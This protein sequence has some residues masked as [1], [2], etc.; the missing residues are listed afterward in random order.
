MKFMIPVKTSNI[1]IVY[2]F[3]FLICSV[4][5]INC[6]VEQ[7]SEDKTSSYIE[8]NVVDTAASIRDS[9]ANTFCKEF[10]PIKTVDP[11]KLK[12]KFFKVG[13]FPFINFIAFDTCHL[14]PVPRNPL[15]ELLVAAF[16]NQGW[17]FRLCGFPENDFN[18][19]LETTNISIT[20]NTA[21][22]YGRLYIRLTCEFNLV[23]TEFITNRD[24]FLSFASSIAREELSPVDD[25]D[26]WLLDSLLLSEFL[27]QG[28]LE[29]ISY[30]ST[31]M[32]FNTRHYVWLLSTG[33]LE[34]YD[35]RI[36]KDGKI[37]I[38]EHVIID[39]SI[40]PFGITH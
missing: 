39:E 6:Q 33:K 31:T 38:L 23:L 2:H 20:N 14:S 40:G 37:E 34:R 1:F 28:E 16:D 15:C 18:S 9:I 27:P 5:S 10:Y 24:D 11:S 30:D 7:Y 26:T 4:T 17:K 19:M 3:L 21:L 8:G 12:F 22:S 36:E 25:M 35:L 13:E 32:A 29:T